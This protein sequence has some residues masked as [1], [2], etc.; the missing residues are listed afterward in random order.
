M[1]DVREMLLQTLFDDWKKYVACQDAEVLHPPTL[2]RMTRSILTI[3]NGI[4]SLNCTKWCLDDNIWPM[5]SWLRKFD[6]TSADKCSSSRCVSLLGGNAVELMAYVL[7]G[8]NFGGRINLQQFEEFDSIAKKSIDPLSPWRVRHSI[9]NAID[10][11]GILNVPEDMADR[12]ETKEIHQVSLFS[13]ALNLLQD[14]D[15][16]V[17]NAASKAISFASASVTIYDKAK[18][19]LLPQQC[20][21][22]VPLLSLERAFKTSQSFASSDQFTEHLFSTIFAEC[23]DIDRMLISVSDQFRLGQNH[24][25]EIN[26]RPPTHRRIF[27]E[28]EP[29]P[30]LEPLLSLQLSVYVLAGQD[31]SIAS[32][33][34][35]H[36]DKLLQKCTVVLAKLFEQLPSDSI[37]DISR[38]SGVFPYMHGVILGSAAAI[39]LGYSD[40]YDIVSVAS[41][42]LAVETSSRQIHP[43]VFNAIKMLSESKAT[44]AKRT[45][46]GLRRCCF[47]VPMMTSK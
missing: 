41:R 36:V 32:R 43:A 29:N 9:A 38:C 8:Q 39:Y 24:R 46:S 10:I 11:C 37:N 15:V 19:V 34:T 45:I 27:E 6:G 13:I 1:V 40:P 28:E 3:S 5:L 25:A 33:R 17:R 26:G 44:D 4:R 20:T 21:S 35:D 22:V 47:L 12:F 30:F 2:R 14:N 23:E 42:I 18:R 7:A 16:D 31:P